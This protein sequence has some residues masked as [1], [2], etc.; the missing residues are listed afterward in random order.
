MS[1]DLIQ[2]LKAGDADKVCEAIYAMLDEKADTA[3]EELADKIGEDINEKG[4]AVRRVNRIRGGK[5][6][7]R[8][9]V[10]GAG[11]TDIKVVSG[12]KTRIKS[13]EK[14]AR[15]LAQRKG[16]KKRKA[17]AG[18]AKIKRKRTLRKRKSLG[19]NR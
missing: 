8:K 2:H 10:R 7:R 5:V 14:R 3:I 17:T 9:K 11:R 1:K 6:Q 19:F 4:R 18:R 12:K 16:A 13:K 15:K